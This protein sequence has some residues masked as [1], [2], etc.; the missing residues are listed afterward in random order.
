MSKTYYGARLFGIYVVQFSRG[1]MDKKMTNYVD[2]CHAVGVDMIYQDSLVPVSQLTCEQRNAD[3]I[4]CMTHKKYKR[5]WQSERRY[6]LL[7]LRSSVEG[8]NKIPESIT[9]GVVKRLR[10][11]YTKPTKPSVGRIIRSRQDN[12]LKSIGIVR[13]EVEGEGRLLCLNGDACNT[14]FRVSV[15]EFKTGRIVQ[16]DANKHAILH[17]MLAFR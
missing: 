13:H 15:G 9:D 17:S 12:I 1:E 14:S 8:R 11:A 6:Y 3:F 7:K 10:E 16:Y 2:T 4:F 5:R